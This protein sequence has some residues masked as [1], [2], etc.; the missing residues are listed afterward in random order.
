MQFCSLHAE[1]RLRITNGSIAG[2]LGVVR[3]G[4]ITSNVVPNG[5]LEGIAVKW[6]RDEYTVNL[7]EVLQSQGQRNWEC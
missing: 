7:R 2:M 4:L 5:S 3:V 1:S 6:I